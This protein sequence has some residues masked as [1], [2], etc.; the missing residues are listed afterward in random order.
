MRAARF[1]VLAGSVAVTFMF[2]PDAY[3][4]FRYPKALVYEG[5]AILLLALAAAAVI[6]GARPSK[7]DWRDRRLAVPL[8]AFTVMAVLTV[9]STRPALS[10]SALVAG[11]ATLVVF[12]ATFASS[13]DGS[14][15][16]VAVPTA[17]TARVV[18][19]G[20]DRKYDLLSC[21]H[22]VSATPEVYFPG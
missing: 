21:C 1:I 4:P 10:A 3:D 7:I 19:A 5:E 20:G 17:V 11:A 14:W 9:T 15:I 22:T 16:V 6:L 2:V 13:R 12:L 8:F 18:R